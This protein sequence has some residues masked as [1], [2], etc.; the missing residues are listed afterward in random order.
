METNA[1]ADVIGNG[2]YPTE[3]YQNVSTETNAD[4]DV[5]GNEIYPNR[6]ISECF[7]GNEC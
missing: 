1:D 3:G 6:R 5:V 2:V 4:V 7:H